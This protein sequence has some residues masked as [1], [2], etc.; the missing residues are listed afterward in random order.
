LQQETSSPLGIVAG[1][2]RF[3]YLLARKARQEGR[4]VIAIAFE[5]QTQPDM[6]KAADKLFWFKL[7]EL[8]RPLRT[9]RREGVRQAILAG[10]IQH[11]SMYKHLGLPDL[12]ALKIFAGLPDRRADTILKAVA[13]E[14][15]KEGIELLS[16]ATYLSDFIPQKGVLTRRTPGA[17]EEKDI[18]LGLQVA[19]QLAGL[20]V[21]QTVVVKAGAVIAVEAM[22]GTDAC[23]ERAGSI[24]RCASEP[25]M[26]VV[27]VAKPKQ[28]LRFDLPVIGTRTVEI[29]KLSGA[30][31]L[32]VE[33]GKTLILDRPEVLRQAD[34]AGIAVVAVSMEEPHG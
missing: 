2:G 20:D 30:G 7:G 15:A 28:D 31:T 17:A 1:Y 29:L 21:G 18:R 24:A 16:S 6:E 4:R 13:Q 33:A 22:E 3:P 23:I 34:E 12:R 10:K 25:G 32:A 8:D 5:G 26:V 19:K 27:K 11:N 14:F 9:L